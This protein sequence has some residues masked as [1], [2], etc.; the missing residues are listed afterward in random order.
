MVEFV[1]LKEFARAFIIIGDDQAIESLPA[2]G[3]SVDDRFNERRESKLARLEDS[4]S[5]RSLFIQ[6]FLYLVY[7]EHLRRV[8]DQRKYLP[9]FR[10]DL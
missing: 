1:H 3:E 5:N 10:P 9:R 7:Q 4:N 8:R 6:A 2:A